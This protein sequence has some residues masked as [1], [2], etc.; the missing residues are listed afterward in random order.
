MSAT[1]M[2]FIGAFIWI[3]FLLVLGVIV[4]AKITLFQRLLMP[5]SLIGGLIGFILMQFDLVGMPTANGFQT[6]SESTF[7]IITFHLFAFSFV[8]IGLTKS[9]SNKP[10]QSKT[11]VKGATWIA[12]MCN[13]TYSIQILIGISVFALWEWFTGTPTEIINGILLG[14]GFTSGPGQAQAQGTIWEAGYA[15]E[16]AV[17]TGLAFAACGFLVAG[18][19][20]SWLARHLILCGFTECKDNAS[21]P[22]EFLTGILNADDRQAIA[23]ETTHNSTVNTLGFHFATMLF[24]YGISYLIAFSIEA[25]SSHTVGVLAFGFLF[26]I[27][28]VV[29]MGFLNILKR[30]KVDYIIDIGMTKS[31]TSSC[32]DLLICAVFLGI[33][34]SAIQS[35]LIPIL[36]SVIIA[37]TAT[38]FICIYFGRKLPE[39]GM[40]RAIATFG[41]ATGTGSNALLLLR[42][43]DP[44]FKS[45]VLMEIGMTMVAQIIINLPFTLCIP[46]AP[47]IGVLNMVFIM[48]AMAIINVLLILWMSK[49]KN[50]SHSPE[51]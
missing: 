48:I 21:L 32:V 11:V 7:A 26:I 8:G 49:R 1:F 19:G 2:P 50:I 9:E 15:I 38:G 17:N 10:T 14:T 34:I 18:L 24:L 25:N 44:K 33:N 29:A 45:P 16:N 30:L 4:R 47:A 42:I 22:K 13:V 20:G 28:L 23:M 6:I 39:Y 51:I 27:G 31:L 37:A 41:Y 3:G 43:V 36:L 12:L 5:A 35:L 46:M 40:E